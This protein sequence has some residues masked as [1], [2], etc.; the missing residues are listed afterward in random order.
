VFYLHDI[1]Y[2]QRKQEPLLTRSEIVAFKVT[3][4]E[5]ALFRL[6]ARSQGMSV[7]EFIRGAVNARADELAAQ[8]P[9]AAR[10]EAEPAPAS[11]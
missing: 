2:S 4:A 1:H 7:S 9:G 11:T 10:E 5:R 6:A 8:R 3:P